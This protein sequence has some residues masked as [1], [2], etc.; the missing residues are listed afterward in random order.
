MR[1][2]FDTVWT[3]G[4]FCVVVIKDLYTGVRAQA[5]YSSSLLRTCHISRGTGQG[6]IL[7]P[8]RYKVYIN[9][10]LCTLTQHS[11]ALSLNS[12]KLQLHDAIYWPR[13]HSNSSIHILSYTNLHNNAAWIQNNRAD[14][15]HRVIVA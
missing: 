14:K 8:F 3:D 2:A 13:F 5:H 6:R 15:S 12:L 1:K 7:A 10:L 11:C 9:G 4:L